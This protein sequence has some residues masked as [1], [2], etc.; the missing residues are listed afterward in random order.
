MTLAINL[1]P[2]MRFDGYFLFSDLLDMP[3]LQER[4]F[5]LARWR[6][7]QALF[8]FGGEPPERLPLPAGRA[9]S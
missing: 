7:R 2:F 4:A 6:L 5:R 3:N 8:G 1:N 9:R